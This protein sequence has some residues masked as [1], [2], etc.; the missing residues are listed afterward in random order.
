MKVEK[1]MQRSQW[2]SVAESLSGRETVAILGIVLVGVGSAFAMPL[3]MAALCM[4]LAVGAISVIA[5][6]EP[7]MEPV[8]IRRDERR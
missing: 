4:L 5:R 8:V 7:V 1:I 3:W 6:D 2:S